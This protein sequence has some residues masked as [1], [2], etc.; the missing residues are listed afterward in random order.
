[1]LKNHD[2]A[3]DCVQ[4]ALLL[5][6]ARMDQFAGTGSF[7]SWVHTILT[8]QCRLVYRR[9]R[10]DQMFDYFDTAAPDNPERDLIQADLLGKVRREIAKVPRVWRSVLAATA[11]GLSCHDGANRC[12]LTVGA[13]K[14]RVVRARRALRRRILQHEKKK[15]LG[16]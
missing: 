11:D 9:H 15:P 16:K 14:S 4:E 1:M 10:Q 7:E 2:D 6:F 13:F 12:G 3:E 8:N 5:A